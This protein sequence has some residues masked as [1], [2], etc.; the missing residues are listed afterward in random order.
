MHSSSVFTDHSGR[1]RRTMRLLGIG[2]GVVIAAAL[3]LITVG[4]AGGPKA[5]IISWALPRPAGAQPGQPP[6][7][8]GH[9][10]AGQAGSSGPSV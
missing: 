10:G 3:G 8:A 5:P 6:A 4:L 1:R 9:T 7:A 2:A